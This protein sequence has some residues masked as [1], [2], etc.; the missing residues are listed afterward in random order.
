MESSMNKP[1]L[2]HIYR[3][4]TRNAAADALDAEAIAWLAGGSATDAQLDRIASSAL[5]ADLIHFARDLESES[6]T[7]SESVNG[8]LRADGAA[9]RRANPLRRSA[10]G[11][12]AWRI[13]SAV[14][15]SF[16]TVV[17]FWNTG[18]M[19][20]P[21]SAPMANGSVAADHIFNA[22]D[23]HELAQQSARPDRIFNG[24]FHSDEIFNSRT[25]G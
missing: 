4:G 1:N 20:T 19:H 18:R 7:L 12:R 15:A 21:S 10:N 16:V 5:H 22:L 24:A 14:A 6:I 8:L 17:V 3:N 2:S 9:H 23:D 11:R 25:G 13:A